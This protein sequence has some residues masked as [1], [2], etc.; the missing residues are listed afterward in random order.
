MQQYL[1]K[2]L[3]G[4]EPLLVK[5]L[6]EL[7]AQNIQAG[8]RSVSF[9]G[10]KKLLYRVNYESR[11]AIRVLMPIYKFKTK[12]ENHFYKKLYEF[13]WTEYLS[14]D[15]TLA[16]DGVTQ[17][18]YITHSKYLALKAKDSIC[19]QFRSRFGERPDVNVTNPD[20]RFNVH[21]GRENDCTVSIDT[22]GDSLHKRGYRRDAVEAP[23]NEVLAAG[24]VLQSGWNRDCA[25]VDPMSGSGT[26]AIEAA[27]FAKNIP[28]Q[29]YR[30]TKFAFTKSKDFD[31]ALWEEVKREA[32]AN[33]RD[34]NY[35][36][37]GSDKDFE[38][39]SIARFNAGYANVDDIVTFSRKDFFLMK[40]PEDKGFLVFNP[41]YDERLSMEDAADFY[42]HV[43]DTLKKNW[44]GWEAWI[45]SSNMG[46]LKR[47]GLRASFKKPLFN[48][49]LECKLVRFEMYEGS[50]RVDT[51][52]KTEE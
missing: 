36:I 37:L 49:K 38:A 2:T 26:I 40:Q 43:G 18:N 51:R 30:Q 27:M 42:K 28:P 11:T 19:D 46:A 31:S 34:F 48:G 16:I 29:M 23:M 25:F 45:I 4:L 52:V 32:A 50:K 3:F 15:Q 20:V 33:I 24:L 7:G 41:P 12:H 39:V 13:D 6:E 9:E 21:L 35:P 44:M 1:A 22:S 8:A 5:E 14:L 17:S 10:D 47:L